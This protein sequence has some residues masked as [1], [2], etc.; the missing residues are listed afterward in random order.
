MKP[1]KTHYL[2]IIVS[3]LDMMIH[4]TYTIW[5]L[6]TS[7]LRFWT[8]RHQYEVS[9]SNRTVY[10]IGVAQDQTELGRVV[11]HANAISRVI[12]VVNHVKLKKKAFE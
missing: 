7:S 8:C 3:I 5:R 9:T 4:S 1:S 6:N 11:A 10:L 12:N 2:A